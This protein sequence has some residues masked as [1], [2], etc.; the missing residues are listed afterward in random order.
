MSKDAEQRTDSVS[1]VYAQ[2]LIDLAQ[3]DGAVDALAGEAVEL[4]SLLGRE[5]DLKS[6]LSSR[7][8]ST[9]QRSALVE[10]LFKGKVSDVLYRFLQVVNRKDRL[11]SLEGILGAYGVLVADAKGELD[12]DVFV[13]Q[14][15]T[16]EAGRG[17]AD[18]IGQAVGKR[19]HLHQHVDPELIGGLK[20]R[21][22]D[23]LI[24]GSVA[25]QLKIMKRKLVEA[26]REQARRGGQLE[27]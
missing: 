9:A 12:V 5:P 18:S 27:N 19:V 7:A 25:T 16:D 23:R 22:G 4:L 15:L 8:L 24:D 21:V 2:A 20:V 14:A 3:A 13:A 26:G 1:R 6:L 11:G 17:V 10:K